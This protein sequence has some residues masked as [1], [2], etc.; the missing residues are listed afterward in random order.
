MLILS[1]CDIKAGFMGSEFYGWALGWSAEPSYGWQ[2]AFER[3]LLAKVQ[4][5]IVHINH[6]KSSSWSSLATPH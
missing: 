6:F 1:A 2:L 5:H 4:Y 3:R